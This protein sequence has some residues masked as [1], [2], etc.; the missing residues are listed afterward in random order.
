MLPR[1]TIKNLLGFVEGS[2]IPFC[3]GGKGTGV[4]AFMEMVVKRGVGI[5]LFMEMEGAGI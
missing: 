2:S 3:I 1:H 4:R 5:E